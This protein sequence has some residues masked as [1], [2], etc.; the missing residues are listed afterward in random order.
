MA[1]QEQKIED[2]SLENSPIQQAQAGANLFAVQFNFLS[3]S[4]P[5]NP[6]PPIVDWEW[7]EQK[8]KQQLS[9]IRKR[10]RDT[11]GYDRTLMDV[12]ARRT[13]LFGATVITG[14]TNVAY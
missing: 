13:T 3:D 1:S 6:E 8:L 14:R 4:K 12:T 10:L 5:E 11:L 9:D 7:G 2:S